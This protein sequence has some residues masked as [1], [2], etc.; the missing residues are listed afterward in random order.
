M[1]PIRPLLIIALAI[2]TGLIIRNTLNSVPETPEVDLEK[3][4]GSNPKPK[5]EDKS[6]RPFQISFNE[7]MIEDLIQR[8]RNRRPLTK[9]LEG[10]KSEYGMNTNYLE[11]ILKYWT[12]KYEFKKREE[13]LN[14]FKRYKT[15]IQGLD[16]H[17][18]RVKPNNVKEGV[19][20]LPLLMLH[21]WPTSSQEY[22]K[23]IPLLTTPRKV[24]NFVFE[25]IAA[26]LP[27]FGFSE[28]TNKPLLNPVEI[29]II[30]R[31]LMQR[32]GFEKFYIQAGDWGSQC[33]THMATLFPDQILGFHTNMPISSRSISTVKLLL[34]SL[35]PS[36]IMDEKHVHRVYPLKNLFSYL[37]RESGYFH[38]QAT[39]PDTIGVGLTDS[40]TGLAAYIMEKIAIC[41]NRDQLNT[42]HGGLESLEIDDVL[43]ILT[44]IWTNNCIV[45]SMRIYAEGLSSPTIRIIH[46]IPTTVPTAAINFLYEV[47]YQPDWILRDKFPNLVR[48][49]VYE[50]GGHFAALQTPR[51]LVDDVFAATV[52][53]IKFHSKSK[54]Q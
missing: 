5:E 22:T 34:G 42:D 9:P 45:T 4:W 8:I 19:D 15:K 10:I 46:N 24:H 35:F 7:T 36:L 27:G 28:G 18:I 14:Q 54:K 3:W 16:I 6:I 53:F 20:V 25:V 44:I 30:M 13:R 1:S 50:Y 43:D 38:L 29:G 11:K 23:V 37:I 12:E 26:D 48:S 17:F 47:I 2:W 21:G 32:L 39:K 31:N 33:A 52:E 49:T 51:E 40:P 41:S